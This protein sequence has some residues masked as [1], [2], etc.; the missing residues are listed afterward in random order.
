MRRV[1]IALAL[2]ATMVSGAAFAQQ[3]GVP[4]P[5]ATVIVPPAPIAPSPVSS[6]I[7]RAGGM[8]RMGTG[9]NASVS[10]GFNPG[11]T[12]GVA[13]PAI[14]LNPGLDP[15]LRAAVLPSLSAGMGSSMNTGSNT[16]L[17]MGMRGR[18]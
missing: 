1:S 2:S 9:M 17:G 10:T 6:A 14:G 3:A 18:R 13:P 12:A 11:L 16:G 5:A 8:N 15:S 4:L 7:P